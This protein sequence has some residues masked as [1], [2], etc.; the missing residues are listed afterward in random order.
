M[1]PKKPK[2]AG[3]CITEYKPIKASPAN[4]TATP[5]TAKQHGNFKEMEQLV[6]WKGLIVLE[7][8]REGGKYRYMINGAVPAYGKH[9]YD[10][11]VTAKMAVMNRAK[12]LLGRMM[13]DMELTI[14]ATIPF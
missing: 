5:W 13:S 2:Y 1:I 7:V 3:P 4:K 11:M 9:E 6:L 8:W 14:D 10:N 12:L